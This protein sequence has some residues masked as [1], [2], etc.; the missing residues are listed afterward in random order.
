MSVFDIAAAAPWAM[1]PERVEDV[2]RVCARENEATPETLEAYRSQQAA[3]TERARVRDGVGL[4]YVEG[5]LFKRANLFVEFSGATSYDI[6]RRDLQALMDDAS[7][8]SILMM[9]DSPGG[10]ANGCDEMAAA[11]YGMRGKKPITAYVSGQACSGAYWI[12]SQADEIVVSDAA[13]LGSIGVVLGV[14]DTSAADE[15][16]GVRKIEFVSSQSPGKRPDVNTDEGRARIQSMVDDLAQVFVSAVA[17]GRGVSPEDVISKFQGGGV[18]I[19]D[20]AVALGMADRVG[21]VE[22]EISALKSRALKARPRFTGG[23]LVSDQETPALDAG[24]IAADAANAANARTKAITECADAVNYPITAKHL[25]YDT[26]VSVEQAAEILAAVAKDFNTIAAAAPVAP[27]PSA[28]AF[29]KAKTEAGAVGLQ[30]A[31]AATS[32]ADHV[33]S[34]WGKHVSNA[35]ARIGASA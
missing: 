10:E 21:S 34:S 2:L 33:K 16:R 31:Q 5:P 29:A 14:T 12:A 26:A 32:G 6:M 13:I 18:A 28:E 9:I 23:I 3:K 17:R 24:K 15:K 4:I 22:S 35:N 19:G 20:K 27:A 11:V 8:N 1:M 7:V 30:P 25:A